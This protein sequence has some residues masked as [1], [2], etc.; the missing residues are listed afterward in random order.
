M[1]IYLKDYIHNLPNRP[2]LVWGPIHVEHWDWSLKLLSSEMV[3]FDVGLVH[4]LSG[5]STI[6]K[7]QSSLDLGHIS[8]LNLYLDD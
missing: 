4:E 6:P 5:G 8:H 3:M 1:S 2:S 7:C